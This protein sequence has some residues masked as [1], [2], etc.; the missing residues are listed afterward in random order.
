MKK[1]IAIAS[2]AAL[3]LGLAACDSGAENAAEVQAEAARILRA[4]KK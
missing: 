4:Y 3:G 1:L 2:A